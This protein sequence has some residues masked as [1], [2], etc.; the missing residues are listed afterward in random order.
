M[1]SSYMC[2]NL[3]DSSIVEDDLEVKTFR[4]LPS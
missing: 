1:F 3:L 4:V 2:L